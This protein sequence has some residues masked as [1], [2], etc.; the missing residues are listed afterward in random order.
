M[1]DA[2]SISYMYRKTMIRKV[3]CIFSENEDMVLTDSC[4]RKYQ[5]SVV[6]IDLDPKPVD[7]I[8]KYHRQQSDIVLAF[9]E[10]QIDITAD[11]WVINN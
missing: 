9:T 2:R 5:F 4:G 11:Q 1:I 6:I 8:K 10:D 7:K 3:L